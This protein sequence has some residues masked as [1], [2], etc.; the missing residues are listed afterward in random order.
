MTYLRRVLQATVVLQCV[1]YLSQ[2]L[3]GETAVFELMF[4]VADLDESTSLLVAR[5]GAVVVLAASIALC[6][7]RLPT[8]GYLIGGWFALSAAAEM[9]LGGEPFFR[10]AL[11]AHAIRFLAP[12]ALVWLPDPEATAPSDLALTWTRRLLRAGVALTFL[13]H[14]WEALQLHPRFLDYLLLASRRLLGWPLAQSA[15]SYILIVIGAI[16]VVL[17]I[18]VLAGLRSRA[19]FGYMAFW[20]AI[21]ALARTV[22]GGP[23]AYPSTLV[24]AANAGGP[25]A[26]L[27]MTLYLDADR[28]DDTR[29]PGRT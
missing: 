12:V 26:L 20:G 11:A 24:R 25:L 18:A 17:G 21:T 22:H 14:G 27:M 10:L 15:A 13:A 5:G 9:Q 28:D 6:L 23:W 16:D 2:S 7:K 3:L 8:L 19:V 29:E 1:G 4:L